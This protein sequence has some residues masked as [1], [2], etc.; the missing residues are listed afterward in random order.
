MATICE[1]QKYRKSRLVP[2]PDFEQGIA[3]S[4]FALL[5]KNELLVINTDPPYLSFYRVD[6]KLGGNK[7]VVS[8][9]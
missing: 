2:K 1:G 6:Y 9:P 3:F 8:S 5:I 4:F 7:N